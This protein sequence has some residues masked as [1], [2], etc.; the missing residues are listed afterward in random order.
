MNIFNIEDLV[1]KQKNVDRV[2]PDVA[3]IH[4]AN[5]AFQS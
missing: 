2:E 3:G 1:E 5:P 4:S